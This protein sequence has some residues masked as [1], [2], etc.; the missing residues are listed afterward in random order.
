LI[1]F[2]HIPKTAGT[3]LRVQLSSFDNKRL[4]I[5]DLEDYPFS[6]NKNVLDS[7]EIFKS[8][9][10]SNKDI[11]LSSYDVIFGHFI[12]D[13]Y[14]FLKNYTDYNLICFLRNPTERTIS[15][16]FYWKKM[17]ATGTVGEVLL[18]N[19]P[20][21]NQIAD[22]TMSLEEF[23]KLPQVKNFYKIYFGSNQISDFSF[24]GISERFDESIAII[25]KKFGT[26]FIS[27]RENVVEKVKYLEE[28][29]NC[30]HKIEKVNEENYYYYNLALKTFWNK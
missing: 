27:L 25:N 17:L 12:A 7:R 13:K 11:L 5:D 14:V 10:I 4:L 23:S 2:P 16:Y 28:I 22:N 1:I 19:L 20:F 9:A 30:Y 6:L 29:N 15:H 3:S 18:N 26:N 8:K 21:L 24:I